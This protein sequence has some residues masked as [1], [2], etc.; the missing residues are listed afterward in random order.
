M[1]LGILCFG[2]ETDWRATAG[3]L[4]RISDGWDGTGLPAAM[5]EVGLKFCEMP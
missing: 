3:Q 1:L 4:E 5:A 2:R